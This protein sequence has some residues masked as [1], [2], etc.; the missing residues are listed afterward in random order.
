MENSAASSPNLKFLPENYWLAAEL[1]CVPLQGFLSSPEA[2]QNPQ[3][4]QLK[5]MLQLAKTFSGLDLEKDVNRVTLFL[6]GDPDE[7]PQYLFVVQG[8]F[9][10]QVVE[11]RLT[12]TLGKSVSK[13]TYKETTVYRGSEWALSFPAEKIIL[14]GKEQ[15][16]HDAIDRLSGHAVP[17]PAAV[18]KVLERTPGDHLLW[19][20]VRPRA[21][22]GSK[23]VGELL[24][25]NKDLAENLQKLECV[26]FSC[27]L[28]S[29]GLLV[30]ALGYALSADD[31][32]Q[33][34]KY[35]QSR[36][37]SS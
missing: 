4:A 1:D 30:N 21:I 14:F 31:A 36:K 25:K 2:Q 28:S 37:T 7:A 29:D 33:V 10:N 17:V 26:S 11:A 23:A 20:A 18:E 6:A 15:L 5:Q 19:A 27:S 32:N 12:Q 3:Y 24:E 34:F 9:D 13:K 16:I 35:L 8:T 22:L